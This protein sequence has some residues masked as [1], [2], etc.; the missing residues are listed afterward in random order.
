MEPLLPQGTQPAQ[1][2]L[3]LRSPLL[4]AEPSTTLTKAYSTHQPRKPTA[5]TPTNPATPEALLHLPRPPQTPHHLQSPPLTP[6]DTHNPRSPPLSRTAPPHRLQRL[7]W[8][9]TD[10]QGIPG[11]SQA[12]PPPPQHLTDPRATCSL[13]LP[14]RSGGPAGSPGR[15]AAPCPPPGPPYRGS[16]P[17]G[18]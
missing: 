12:P 16:A 6:R 18:C 9:L 5:R 4:P 14:A 15:P 1:S 7:P 8:A 3:Y 10:S 2:R 11:P 17:L 13:E